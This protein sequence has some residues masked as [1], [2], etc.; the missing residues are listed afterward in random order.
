MQCWWFSLCF[1][2]QEK[3]I[4]GIRLDQ[5]RNHILFFSR[6]IDFFFFRSMRQFSTRFRTLGLFFLTAHLVIVRLSKRRV[7]PLVLDK[8]RSFSSN[9]V[10][11][12]GFSEA[13]AQR[14]K[15]FYNAIASIETY[16]SGGYS[17]LNTLPFMIY[18]IFVIVYF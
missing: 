6:L 2:R 1:M 13:I 10:L 12:S 14:L 4:Q 3:K 7:S 5:R 11:R 8:H 18:R 17:A 15:R 16:Y 9:R